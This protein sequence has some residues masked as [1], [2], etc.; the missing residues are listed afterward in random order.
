MG[1]VAPRANLAVSGVLLTLLV[2]HRSS[3]A[4]AITLALTAN[5]IVGWLA[6]PLLGR[7]SDRTRF[8]SGRRVPYLSA[9]LALM[10]VCTWAYTM[11][12]GYWPLVGLI[13]VVK[14][15]SV[16]F[17]LNNIAAIPE[18]FGK[19]RTLK[20][21]LA[22]TILGIGVSFVIKVTAISTWKTNV[23][24]TYNLPFRL[25]ALIMVIAAV[26][27]VL[28]VREAPAVQELVEADRA[29]A[30]RP[31][32]E[33]WAR[34][35]AVPNAK[36]LLWGIFLFWSGISAT[37][38]LAIVY[39]QQVQHAGAGIQTLA[40]WITG[41]PS[42]LFGLPVGLLISRVFSRKAV[43]VATPIIGSGFLV[44]QYFSTHFWQSVVLAIVGSPLFCAFVFSTLTMLL[45]LLPTEGGMGEI[46][47][48]LVA[49]FSVT[50]LLFSF[51][52]AWAVDLTHNYRVI[53]L[54]PAA[55]YLVNGL[56]MTGLK[57]PEW[58][59]RVPPAGELLE[60]IGDSILD[61]TFRRDNSLLGGVI[62]AEDADATSWFVTARTILGDP[63]APP[64]PPI[65]EDDV[66][67]PVWAMPG[68][69]LPGDSGESGAVEGSE[70]GEGG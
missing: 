69:A 17:Q 13:L 37:S 39:F 22:I 1:F 33:E 16:I 9:G 40:G 57:V 35:R 50:A 46:L 56:V 47:G 48:K 44:V 55:V 24:S 60:R 32:R 41:V 23:P 18:T 27:V 58:S 70:P 45:Q 59:R 5:R 14:T 42:I 10:G 66:E 2:T 3:G 64:G 7:L 43:A 26:M 30:P 36:V 31:F 29:E 49:P 28:L 51:L 67:D 38:Y 63:Y 12:G 65:D 68:P 25:A 52:A 6:Y 11:V 21:V 54:F 62:T 15:A 34:I 53:W 61:Q 8:A 19:S 20:A 4:V